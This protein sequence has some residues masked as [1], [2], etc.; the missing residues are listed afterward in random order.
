MKEMEREKFSK[1]SS[2]ASK[3]EIKESSDLK[4]K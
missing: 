1:K 2:K 3:K 4:E